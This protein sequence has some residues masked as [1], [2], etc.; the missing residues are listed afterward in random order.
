MGLIPPKKGYMEINDE[1]IYIERNKQLLV[2]WRSSI[3]YVPQNIF[4]SDFS[5]KE[6]VAFGLNKK[7]IDINKVN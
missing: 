6:N 5:I 1:D 4:L 2:N 7:D 3:S